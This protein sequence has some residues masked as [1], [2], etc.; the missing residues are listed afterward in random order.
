MIKLP[1]LTK[2]DVRRL[3]T[4]Q[5]FERGEDYYYSEAVFDAQRRGDTLTARVEGSQYEPYRVTVTLDQAGIQDAYFSLPGQIQSFVSGS[6]EQYRNRP[7]PS[8]QRRKPP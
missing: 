6:P 7:E 3:A 8:S 5:S 4:S 2:N 1:K